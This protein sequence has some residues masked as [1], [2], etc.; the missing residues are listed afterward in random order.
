MDSND[1]MP[2]S[3]RVFLALAIGVSAGLFFLIADQA[4]RNYPSA[5]GLLL[6]D[7]QLLGGD[8]VAF[9][10]GGRLF[11]EDRTRLYDLEYQRE[12]RSELLSAAGDAA[13]VE[14]PFVYPPL[15]AALASLFT[16]YALQ[17]AFALWTLVALVVSVS[18]LVLL[19]RV[20]G[21]TRTVPLPVL[22]LLSFGFVP[23]SMNTLLGG[24]L[25]WLGLGILAAVSTALLQ[26]REYLAG[27]VMSLSYYKPPLFLFLFIALIIGRSWR[28]ALGFA[29]G[30]V[31]LVGGT[32]FL[33]GA[34]GAMSFLITASRYVYG[35]ELLEGVELP[36]TQGMGLVAL[37]VSLASSF[38]LTLTAL[39]P[40]F[41]VLLW[42]GHRLLKSRN[43]GDRLFALLLCCTATLAF[44]VQIIRYDLA[45]L[46]VPMVLGVAWQ[47]RGPRT[48]RI[49]TLLVIAGF[50]FEFS[51]REVSLGAIIL[52]GSSILFTIALGLLALQG[53]Q[54]LKST[55]VNDFGSGI[56]DTTG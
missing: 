26:R 45:M 48:A 36:P 22:L 40:L 9:Y 16:R 33:V 32:L 51:F 3:R 55:G 6:S 31:L 5:D 34:D 38:P 10:V 50:Y 13:A 4:V 29:S 56:A 49:A 39:A 11:R 18:S 14:L 21:A 54:S 12:F 35:Q 46:L 44:S 52:N 23:F 30:A 25:S 37:G 41:I 7:G 1:Q 8:F 53:F 42:L 24:Q 15:I 19:M 28:F 27:V 20:S 17:P 43:D 2:S 47:G